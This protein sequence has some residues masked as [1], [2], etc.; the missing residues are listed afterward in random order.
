MDAVARTSRLTEETVVGH[1]WE[2]YCA[3]ARADSAAVSPTV[4]PNAVRITSTQQKARNA[5]RDS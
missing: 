1:G 2:A 3:A 5:D 4:S